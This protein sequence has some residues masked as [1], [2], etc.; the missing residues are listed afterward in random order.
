MISALTSEVAD[1][2]ISTVPVP[3]GTCEVSIRQAGTKAP[4]SANHLRNKVANKVPQCASL[5]SSSSAKFALCSG[6][7][8]SSLGADSGAYA[9][10]ALKGAPKVLSREVRTKALSSA[11]HLCGDERNETSSCVL[12]PKLASKKVVSKLSECIDTR[13]IRASALSRLIPAGSDL[14]EFLAS[15]RKSESL[16]TSPS[17]CQQLGCRW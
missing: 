12:L 15:K 10:S 11:N 2:L 8:G 5:P 1:G 16:Q 17:Y 4:S 13:S 6:F 7:K 14:R 3:Q 9:D